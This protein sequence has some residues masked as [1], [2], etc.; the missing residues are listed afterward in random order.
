MVANFPSYE[1][2]QTAFAGTV[3]SHVFMCPPI[4]GV[5]DFSVIA[6]VPDS[7][8]LLRFDSVEEPATFAVDFPSA[9]PASGFTN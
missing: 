2:F 1:A 6:V 7:P 3:A 5:Q 8:I 4:S 9:I